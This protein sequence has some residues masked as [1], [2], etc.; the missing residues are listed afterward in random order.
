[1]LL[2]GLSSAPKLFSAL[3][4]AL[5]WILHHNSIKNGLH[6]LDDYIPKDLQSA[7]S[8]KQ[9]VVKDLKVLSQ[10]IEVDTASV[11]LWLPRDK[12]EKLKSQLK[13]ATFHRTV[14]NKDSLVGLL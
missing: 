4:D 11:N 10:E 1:M 2:F 12:M 7:P 8:Q 14:P 6:Y 9:I 13:W 5:Q 3:A